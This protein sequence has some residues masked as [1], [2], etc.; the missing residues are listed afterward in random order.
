MVPDEDVSRLKETQNINKSLLTL[1]RCIMTL[2]TGSP[3]TPFRDSVLTRLLA[4]VFLGHRAWLVPGSG[5]QFDER[6][7]LHRGD[8]DLPL[9][10]L[11]R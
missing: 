10:V 8:R 7:S 9:F 4:D 5:L 2:S 6:G 11:R 3:H 1:R